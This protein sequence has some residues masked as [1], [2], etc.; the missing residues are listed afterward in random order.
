MA[1]CSGGWPYWAR[2]QLIIFRPIIQDKWRRNMKYPIKLSGSL[3]II[4]V[5]ITLTACSPAPVSPTPTSTIEPSATPA[6]S[7][8]PEPTF[9]PEPTTAPV[10]TA[11]P[12]LTSPALTPAAVATQPV[13]NPAPAVPDKAQYVTQNFPDGYRFK[14]GTPVTIIWTVKNIGTVGWSTTYTLKYFAGEKGSKNSIPFP[15]TVPPGG[16]VQLSVTFTVPKDLG[17]YTTWWKL[18]NAQGQN[19][20]DVDFKFE[21]SNT[22]GPPRLTPTP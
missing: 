6:P 18:V 22:A 11:A 19:F 8:T 4:I 12:A 1:V 20:S 10:S 2:F 15:K 5:L 21:S 3:A 14:P 17:S 9:P 7:D 13:L 16:E